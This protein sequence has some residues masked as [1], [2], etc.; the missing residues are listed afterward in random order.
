MLT[1]KEFV[2]AWGAD[3]RPL[4]RFSKKCLEALAIFKEDK[5]F[6]MEAGLPEAAAPFL[7]FE[8]SES[9][10]TLAE[11][12]RQ[13]SEFAI[14]RLIGSDGS[15]NPIALDEN[16]D[17]EVVYLDHENGFARVLIN[18]SVRQLCA[19]LLAYRKLVRVT[20][21]RFGQ[22]AFLDGK[23]SP[24]DRKELRRELMRIDEA[25]IQPGCFWHDELENLDANAG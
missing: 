15:G 23:A 13:P 10:P 12:Y 6:L 25:A 5:V 9:L 8:V 16:H 17:G 20:Q 14:Y 18:R 1:P 2:A 3:E 22:D 11:A 4:L 19:S 7:G 24:S 21:M